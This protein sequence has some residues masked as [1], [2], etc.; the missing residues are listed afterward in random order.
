MKPFLALVSLICLTLVAQAADETTATP[1]GSIAW[2]KQQAEI[3]VTTLPENRK[4]KIPALRA[5]LE[6]LLWSHDG[7]QHAVSLSPELD[8]WLITLPVQCIRGAHCRWCLPIRRLRRCALHSCS[9][10]P[11]SFLLPGNA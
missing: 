9:Q 5:P 10:S 2:Q 1:W 6:S 8:S 3:T 4:L 7:K 11:H